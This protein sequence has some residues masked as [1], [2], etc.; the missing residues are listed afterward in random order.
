MINVSSILVLYIM[1]Y[2]LNMYEFVS[3]F[4]INIEFIVDLELLIFNRL[5]IE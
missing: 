1:T 2:R 3:T 5:K 4:V